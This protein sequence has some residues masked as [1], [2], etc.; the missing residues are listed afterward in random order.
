MGPDCRLNPVQFI[1]ADLVGLIDQHEIGTE[2]LLLEQ[3]FQRAFVVAEGRI[4]RSP[5]RQ[6]RRSRLSL[7]LRLRR[8]LR[9]W[10]TRSCTRKLCPCGLSWIL[11]LG[12]SFFIVAPKLSI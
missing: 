1:S 2:Q 6:R 7:R 12:A 11:P 5:L 9:L 10:Q 4:G 3:F 8:L